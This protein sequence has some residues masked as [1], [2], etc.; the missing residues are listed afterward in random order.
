MLILILLHKDYSSV[1]ED[2]FVLNI[3]SMSLH[4]D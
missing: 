1:D 3:N 2:L 4:L